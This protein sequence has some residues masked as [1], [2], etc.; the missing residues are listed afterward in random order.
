MSLNYPFCKLSFTRCYLL[1]TNDRYL[2]IDTSYPKEYNLFKK[3]LIKLN[4][5]LED[6]HH[7]FVTHHHDDH[8][9]FLAYFRD[10]YDIRIII[11]QNA[12]QYLAKGEPEN[13]SQPL[14]K[15][16]KIGYWFMSR[17]HK[18]TFPKIKIDSRDI[19]IT[20]DNDNVLRSIGINGTIL[21]TPGHTD[22]S[23]SIVLDNHDA[24]VGDLAMNFMKIAGIN[25]RPIF[26][27]DFEEVLSQWKKL[28]E[29]RVQQIY[30]AHG[31]PFSAKQLH[32]AYQK[33]K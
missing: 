1:K 8:V 15:R 11:H 31:D 6:I 22:D 9:G 3:Q 18:F 20:G 14:N 30:P 26:F 32:N 33:F 7:V 13:T 5:R 10:E 25:Y 29:L 23:L 2:L 27:Q 19:I 17:F 28:L 16:I 12:V 21:C 24:F 4:I